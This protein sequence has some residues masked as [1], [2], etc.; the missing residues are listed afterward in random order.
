MRA[1]LPE[2]QGDCTFLLAV[3]FGAVNVRLRESAGRVAAGAS[4]APGTTVSGWGVWGSWSI[5]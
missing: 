3:T 5:P 1:G 4:L 2:Q